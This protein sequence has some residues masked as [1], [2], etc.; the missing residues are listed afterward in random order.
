[1]DG[2][3]RATSSCDGWKKETAKLNEF[4]EVLFITLY[5]RTVVRSSN[6]VHVA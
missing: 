2:E 4:E 1:M 3:S 6:A 5:W